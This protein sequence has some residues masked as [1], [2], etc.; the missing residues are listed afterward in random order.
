MVA[1]LEA[2]GQ[3]GAL[4]DRDWAV[5]VELVDLSARVAGEVM[6]VVAARLLEAR[7]LVGQVHGADVAPLDQGV[8]VAVDGGEAEAKVVG[9][10]ALEDLLGRHR[11]VRLFQGLQDGT[12]L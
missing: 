3:G 12:P 8:Q 5:G 7:G 4:E 1:Y 6:M 9:S 10:R 11:S 2:A